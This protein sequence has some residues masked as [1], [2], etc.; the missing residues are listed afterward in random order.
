MGGM[1]EMVARALRWRGEALFAQG[2]L[3]NAEEALNLAGKLAKDIGRVRLEWDIHEA[4]QL[5]CKTRGPDEVAR[6]HQDAVKTIVRQIGENL[7]QPE[8]RAGLP[9]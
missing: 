8:M 1:R 9:G 3:E 5:L 4:L 7:Q 6:K 2:Y